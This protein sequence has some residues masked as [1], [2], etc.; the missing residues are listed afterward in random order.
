MRGLGMLIGGW[1]LAVS[2][3]GC[4]VKPPKPTFC[5]I[6]KPGTADCQ[7]TDNNKKPFI[8]DLRSVDALGYQCISAEDTADLKTYI[9]L[10]LREL[11]KRQVHTWP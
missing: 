8:L 3:S 7:P 2:L 1:F 10:L 11:D 6:Y 4:G 5:N 9:E